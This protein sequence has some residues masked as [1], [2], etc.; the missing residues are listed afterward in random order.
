[1]RVQDLMGKMESMS[2]QK[3]A[4]ERFESARASSPSPPSQQQ[5]QQQQT[6]PRSG[7]SSAKSS[8]R[9]LT[10]PSSGQISGEVSADDRTP[11]PSSSSS[12]TSSSSSHSESTSTAAAPTGDDVPKQG[13][14]TFVCS[15]LE[16]SQPQVDGMAWVSDGSIHFEGMFKKQKK[17]IKVDIVDILALKKS[18]GLFGGEG[19]DIYAKK[20]RIVFL[21]HFQ[22]GIRDAA[23]QAIEK[24]VNAAGVTLQQ[25]TK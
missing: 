7:K 11:P 2:K 20:D 10:S 22:D 18:W 6:P 12:S 16:V 24:E 15:G 3:M 19:I 8:L 23:Y 25:P 9:V 14:A 17:R 5:L 13:V 4:E 21:R 1:M